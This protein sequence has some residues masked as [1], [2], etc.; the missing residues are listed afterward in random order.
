MHYNVPATVKK[1]PDLYEEFFT[2]P[3]LVCPVE[4]FLEFFD[5]ETIPKVSSQKHATR[6]PKHVKKVKKVKKQHFD[7][8]LEQFV[9]YHVFHLGITVDDKV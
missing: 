6:E 7:N 3:L 9:N 5:M 1:H 8:M 2:S 4:V